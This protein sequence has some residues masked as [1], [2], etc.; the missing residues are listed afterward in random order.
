MPPHAANALLD[1]PIEDLISLLVKQF[2][3]LLAEGGV[4]LSTVNIAAIAS[5]AA[6][7]DALP[8]GGDGLLSTLCDLV[9]D[10][11]T[12]LQQRFG[13][14]FGQSLRQAMNQIGGWETT[15]EFLELANYK[16][17]AE[18]RISAGSALLL[19]LGDDTYAAN[20]LEVI[21]EDARRMDVDACFAC[22][23]LCHYTRVNP[24]DVQWLAL[25]NAQLT[26]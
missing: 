17:N 3:R 22:R 8:D 6:A 5:H 9:A 12:E 14:T 11:E 4:P 16:S 19:M 24:Q 25:V 18:L 15:A 2:A 7:H 10:S 13:L 21:A 1:A 20:A 23:G 26:G